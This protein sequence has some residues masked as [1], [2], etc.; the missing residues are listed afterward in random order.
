MRQNSPVQ[1]GHTRRPAPHA[2]VAKAL[3]RLL[4][5]VTLAWLTL[6]L[7]AP[8]AFAVPPVLGAPSASG[9]AALGSAAPV[10]PAPKVAAPARA[11]RSPAAPLSPSPAP[12]AAGSLAPA[13][14]GSAPAGVASAEPAPSASVPTDPALVEPAPAESAV[15]TPSASVPAPPASASAAPPASA[16][17]SS[18]V[19]PAA[20]AKAD[21]QATAEVK[22]KDDAVFRV[23][24]HAP[25]SAEQRAGEATRALNGAVKLEDRDV[26]V[27]TRGEAAV[28]YVGQTPIVQLY[29]EDATLAGDASLTVHA[30]AVAAKVRQAIYAEHT[31]GVIA[32]TVFSISLVIFL[33]LIALYVLRKSGDLE[34]R[35]HEFLNEHAERI[36][37]LKVSSFEVVGRGSTRLILSVSLTLAKWTLRGAVIYGYVVVVTTLFEP[38]RGFAETLTQGLVTPVSAFVGRVAASLPVVVVVG[39]TAAIVLLLLRLS[40]LF[41]TSVSQGETQSEWV[42]RDMAE[43]LAG[44]TN[45]GIVVLALV[46]AAPIVT[47]DPSGAFAKV[48]THLLLALALAAAPILASAGLG[49]VLVLRRHVR[50]GDRI[51]LAKVSG[52]IQHFGLFDL[53]LKDASG[54]ELR[55]PYLAALLSPLRVVTRGKVSVVLLVDPRA[56][57]VQALAALRAGIAELGADTSVSLVS[58]D[59]AGARYRLRAPTGDADVRERLL[60]LAS[61]A[62]LRA[63]I[64]LAGASPRADSSDEA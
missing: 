23:G 29:E 12:A 13:A 53:V 45:V 48:G 28:I 60:L 52:V 33:G 49:A 63:K 56:S 7:A 46:F 59:G 57:Q 38:T 34:R 6:V 42:K 44:L 32:K 36:S 26:R 64:P 30:A 2:A 27:V 1:S 11:A 15:P 25:Q 40:S 39:F 47:G 14:S 61:E 50:F 19:P 37:S 58:L 5:C 8:L 9:S 4:A 43:S 17:P 54:D 10:P 51:E 20:S 62:L 55:V 31:R 24:A 22:L 3:S 16:A 18:S 41:F 35:G 21:A